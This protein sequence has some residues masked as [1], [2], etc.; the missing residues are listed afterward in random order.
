MRLAGPLHISS[1]LNSWA[2]TVCLLMALLVWYTPLQSL[3]AGGL[4]LR[5]LFVTKV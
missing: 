3:Q 5:D 1:H 4:F 2:I